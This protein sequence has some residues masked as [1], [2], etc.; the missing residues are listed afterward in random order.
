[1]INLSSNET[2]NIVTIGSWNPA[3]FSPEWAKNNLAIDKEKDVILAIPMQMSLPP[4]L[5][6]DEV[7][8]YPSTMSLMIDCIEYGKQSRDACS[9]KVER[10]SSLLEHTPVSGVG[11]NFR[12]AFDISEASTLIE[13]FSFNDASKINSNIYR[14]SSSSVRRSFLLDDSMLNLSIE[15][16]VDKFICEFNF[17]SD[18]RQLSEVIVKTSIDRIESYHSQ[19]V[20]FMNTV[21]DID[22]NN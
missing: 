9:Q 5:S 1:M 20:E 16:N 6:V 10:I 13:L 14:L 15:S 11:V 4:R 22:L 2:F 17:H 8:I 19:A 21:Y 3:I 7:N 18:I 12:F